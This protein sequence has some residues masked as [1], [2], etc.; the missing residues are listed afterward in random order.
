MLSG[1][2]GLDFDVVEA[3]R[4]QREDA[5]AEYEFTKEADLDGDA[6]GGN[7]GGGAG[8]GGCEGA[9]GGE[10]GAAHPGHACPGGEVRA[11]QL[12]ARAL[13]WPEV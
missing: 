3:K 13:A 2:L 6:D 8:A 7:D 10:G 4:Q 1:M 11:P 12:A 9:D 5:A